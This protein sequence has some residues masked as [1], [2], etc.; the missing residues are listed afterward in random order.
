MT[1]SRNKGKKGGALSKRGESGGEGGGGLWGGSLLCFRICGQWLRGIA[2][3]SHHPLHPLQNQ[4]LS[5]T[6]PNYPHPLPV[7]GGERVPSERLRG[8]R[9]I[10]YDLA[11]L[12]ME[13]LAQECQLRFSLSLSLS[14]FY[15]WWGRTQVPL[16]SDVTWA[17]YEFARWQWKRELEKERERDWGGERESAVEMKTEQ[18]GEKR[19]GKRRHDG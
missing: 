15:F 2:L 5:C 11:M 12:L 18:S 9:G 6:A 7:Q 19:R 14:Q 1:G 16:Q 10:R 4:R 17:D 3:L 8:G 13:R